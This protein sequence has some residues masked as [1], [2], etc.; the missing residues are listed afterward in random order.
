LNFVKEIMK[1]R[2]ND[3]VVSIVEIY[4]QL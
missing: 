3:I 1:F 4:R 2:E